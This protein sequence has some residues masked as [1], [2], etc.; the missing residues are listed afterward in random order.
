MTR[1]FN[2][3]NLGAGWQSSR[4]LLGSELGELPTFDACV[5][6]DTR[7]EPKAVYD[8]LAWMES[9]CTRNKIVRVSAGDLRA[10]SIE[11]RANRRS[12]DGKRFASI[13]AFTKNADGT[14][15]RTKRQCTKEY[16]II[17]IERW[18][19]RE[20]LGLAHGQRVPSG[21]I[22]RQWYGISDD[23][24]QR[25]SF[26]GKSKKRRLVVGSDLHGDP[27]IHDISMWYPTPWKS[28]VYCLL[29]E[30][31]TPDRKIVE[32]KFFS[33]R[34]SRND[35]GAWLAAKFRGRTIPRSACIG[36]PNRTNEEWKRLTPDEFRD[37][38]AFDAEHRRQDA[39]NAA[40]SRKGLV[41]ELYLHR[42]LVPLPMV[43]LSG[44]GE[45]HGGGCGTLFDG[46]GGYCD[47]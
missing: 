9:Y 21:L 19:R 14:T 13:P 44:D 33:R 30:V 2:I 22:V 31:W 42:Q 37:A 34:Q 25:A 7:W 6:A 47:S 38:A 27:I 46:E 11:F 43:D 45:R 35:V 28:H 3:L 20:L 16:K 40:A 17:P 15:G 32:E 24:G 8:H 4:I 36:C 29:N 1:I 10:D 12:S 18:I 41:G 26:P 5:F 23:E 39:S